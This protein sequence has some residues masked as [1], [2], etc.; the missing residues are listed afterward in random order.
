MKRRPL[1]LEFI[2]FRTGI[3]RALCDP[4]VR[5]ALP[6]GIQND[7]KEAL[8]LDAGA[9]TDEHDKAIWNAVKWSWANLND[10]PKE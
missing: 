2:A 10:V 7:I 1:S 5:K 8:N 3:K 6:N 9:W 4:L